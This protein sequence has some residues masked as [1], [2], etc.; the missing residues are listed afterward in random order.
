M[1]VALMSMCRKWDLRGGSPS[2]QE[3]VGGLVVTWGS[4]H[5]HTLGRASS[6]EAGSLRWSAL[7]QCGP[8]SVRWS[9]VCVPSGGL[10]REWCAC[11]WRGDVCRSEKHHRQLT[12]ALRLSA[13]LPGTVFTGLLSGLQRGARPW[14]A[15]LHLPAQGPGTPIS[16]R[17]QGRHML[18]LQRHPEP[19]LG[20]S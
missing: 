3:Q 6:G 20:P 19:P 11:V 18:R 13:W 1:P 10:C 2:A 12:G 5:R 15:L 7:C 9:A 17:A 8:K 16:N 14:G 4:C